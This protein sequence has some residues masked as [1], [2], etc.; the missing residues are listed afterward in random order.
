MDIWNVSQGK[1]ISKEN[2]REL[3]WWGSVCTVERRWTGNCCSSFPIVS[4]YT[5]ARHSLG[6]V[7]KAKKKKKEAFFQHNTKFKSVIYC[8]QSYKWALKAIRWVCKGWDYQDW[9]RCSLQ[10]QQSKPDDGWRRDVCVLGYQ[11]VFHTRASFIC[12]LSNIQTLGIL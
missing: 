5:G 12:I 3:I 1:F 11:M 9:F 8:Y 7:F 4:C 2:A 10:P 6:C